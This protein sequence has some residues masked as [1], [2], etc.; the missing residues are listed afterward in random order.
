MA[1]QVR[2]VYSS[3]SAELEGVVLDSAVRSAASIFLTLLIT[4]V[5]RALSLRAYA[6]D[7]AAYPAD[8]FRGVEFLV[9]QPD[10]LNF[11]YSFNIGSI[12]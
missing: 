3:S 5:M 12:G 8:F 10:S 7:E 4:L 11:D 6:L 9:T 2:Q 1:F